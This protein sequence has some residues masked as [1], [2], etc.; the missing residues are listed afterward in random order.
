MLDKLD[1]AMKEL[2]R[3]GI[4]SMYEVEVGQFPDV[5]YLIMT[6][7][8]SECCNRDDHR[9]YLMLDGDG[10]YVGKIETLDDVVLGKPYIEFNVAEIRAGL[11][12]IKNGG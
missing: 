7:E 12:Q 8:K 5:A 9:E 10:Q 1:G 11:I 3:R 4:C 6:P 2:V